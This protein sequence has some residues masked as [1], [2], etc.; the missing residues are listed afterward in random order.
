[1]KDEEKTK[2]ELIR[3]L[4]RLRQQIAESRVPET[5]GLASR[6]RDRHAEQVLRR[7]E[8]RFRRL[9]ESAADGLFVINSKGRFIDANQSACDSLGYTREEL[10]SLSPWDLDEGWGPERFSE[11]WKRTVA[12]EFV[13]IEAV[14]RRKDGTSFPVE[15][16]VRLFKSDG[17][18]LMLALA[19]D[20]T[21]RKQAEERIRREAARADALVRVAAR[22]NAHLTL[23]RVLNA[24]C[25]ETACALDTALHTPA[26]AVLLQDE[27]RAVLFPA[28]TFGLPPEYR[29][30][31]TPTSRA[32][33][34]EYTR[35]QGSL[36][37][38]PDAQTLPDLPNAELYARYGIRTIVAVSLTREG[39]LIGTLNVYGLSEPRTFTDDELALLKGLADQAAQAIENAQLR[40]HAQRAA[41]VAERS[42]L[43][44]ELH[45]SVT[46]ALYGLTLYAEAATRFLSSGEV[47]LA[48]QQVREMRET[49]QQ[50]LQEMRLLIFQLRPP[51]LEEGLV[52]A[53]RY[54]LETVE[55]RA[56]LKTELK[57]DGDGRL[58]PEIEEE[59]YRIAQ[60]ALNN[61]L[62][63][64]Q[65]RRITVYL[66]QDQ[67]PV[68]LDIADDGVG[69]NP[70]TAVE[71]GGLG[72]RGMKERA[73]RLGSNLIVKSKPGEG[74]RVRVEI[75]E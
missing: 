9:V 25:E 3:E 7:S 10:L 66:R 59:L 23:E 55:G 15:I 47:D 13:T 48:T 54:R 68:I 30:L 67:Q 36:I 24:V 31:Y 35:Q 22:L 42:R 58:P 1:M 11:L 64:S 71:K 70:T 28:A 5:R 41:V 74:T 2:E 49:A 19:R 20:V 14:H 50:A 43:S 26:V 62:K 12:E 33:Y 18:Q 65:A 38:V 51:I 45:D 34:E 57:V 27:A 8:E 37:V 63:H 73:V 17:R 56:G 53:L 16:R 29:A 6:Q 21:K 72:L 32:I 60:E 44:R 39:Q 40:S 61:A 46:Q 4:Q 69:F 75:F 52:A